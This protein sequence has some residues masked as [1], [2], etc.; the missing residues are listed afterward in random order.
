MVSLV[1]LHFLSSFYSFLILFILFQS[2]PHFLYNTF[3]SVFILN[4]S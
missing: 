3:N 1:Y 4:V 2:T